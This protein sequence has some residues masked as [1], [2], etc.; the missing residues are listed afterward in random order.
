[1]ITAVNLGKEIAITIV[2][3]VGILAE[4][5]DIISSHG[6]NIEAIG[7]YAFESSASVMIVTSE[8]LRAVEALQAKGY[9]S[10]VEKEVLVVE[11]ENKPGALKDITRKLASE[12]IDIKHIYGTV[13]V[14]ACPVRLV[15]STNDNKKAFVLL[16]K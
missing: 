3:R 15:L 11:L 16:K 9:K 13:C 1:M 7:A 6:I 12:Q 10:A 2:N 5:S 8:N 14:G 4:I